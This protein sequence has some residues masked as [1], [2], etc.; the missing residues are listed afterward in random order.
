LSIFSLQSGRRQI[1]P[2]ISAQDCSALYVFA[3]VWQSPA[4]L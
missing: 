4:N 3:G 2:M 1:Q